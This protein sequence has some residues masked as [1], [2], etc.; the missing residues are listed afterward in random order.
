MP[1]G[2]AYANPVSTF[3]GEGDAG[4]WNSDRRSAARRH[5]RSALSL[6]RAT[7]MQVET[8]EV[9]EM[10]SAPVDV[11]QL[12]DSKL[13]QV[14]QDTQLHLHNDLLNARVAKLD[15]AG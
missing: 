8:L 7:R 3:S 4:M 9:R 11:T 2:Q 1:P 15:D 13:W 14:A 5:R 10:L 6:I 12:I